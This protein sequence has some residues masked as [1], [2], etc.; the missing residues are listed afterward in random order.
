VVKPI[1]A[2]LRQG[3]TPEKLALTIALGVA[4][5]VFPILGMATILCAVVALPLGL[6]QVGIQ[7]VNFAVFPFQLGGIPV[8]V[9]LGEWLLDASRASL[10]LADLAQQF[11]EDPDGALRALE[12][13]G[14][15]ATVGWAVIAPLLSIALYAATAPSLRRAFE[16]M[17]E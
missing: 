3:A 4:C 14:I 12:L 13:V 17:R 8:F 15:H 10:S 16:R 2:L 7:V 9:R 11:Q 5:G 1:L 6:N